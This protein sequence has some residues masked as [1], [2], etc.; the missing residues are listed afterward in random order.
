PD[1]S[2]DCELYAVAYIGRCFGLDVNAED[3]RQWYQASGRTVLA[4]YLPK[5][6][7]IACESYWGPK[8]LVPMRSFGLV[9]ENRQSV[10]DHLAAGRIGLAHVHRVAEHGHAIV[11]LELQE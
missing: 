1:P 9:E 4:L 6:Y 8:G 10:A 7:G 3:V 5:A 11:L 2:Q